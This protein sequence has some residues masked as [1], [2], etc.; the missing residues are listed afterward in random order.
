MCRPQAEWPPNRWGPRPSSAAASWILLLTPIFLLH[1]THR[2]PLP[3]LLLRKS[4]TCWPLYDT[5]PANSSHVNTVLPL[6]AN[7]NAPSFDRNLHAHSGVAAL[8][9]SC[10]CCSLCC[11]R[12]YPSCCCSSCS[13]SLVVVV[14]VVDFLLPLSFVVKV[15][16]YSE[17]HTCSTPKSP[18]PAF[19][20]G[21]S[22]QWCVID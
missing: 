12:C 10:C 5:Q 14:I 13:I 3:A 20:G 2:L 8:C 15:S 1:G 19:G 18:S 16:V 9:D 22:F 17:S 21:F 7:I 6:Q 4:L 11:R